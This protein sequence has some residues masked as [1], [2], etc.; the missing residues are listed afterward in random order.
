MS[1]AEKLPSLFVFHG[2]EVFMR[3]Q[4]AQSLVGRLNLE[5]WRIEHVGREKAD[6]P[7][8]LSDLLEGAFFL[9]G[10]FVVVL[11]APNKDYLPVVKQ[12]VADP[13]ES[14]VIVRH[15]K[16]LRDNSAW[17]KLAKGLEQKGNFRGYTKPSFARQKDM[18]RKFCGLMAKKNGKK[19]AGKVADALI[20]KYGA[21]LAQLHGELQKAILL[22]DSQNSDEITIQNVKQVLAPFVE[23]NIFDAVGA[24]EHKNVRQLARILLDIQ[25]S[26]K[27]D[28]TMRVVHAIASSVRKWMLVENTRLRRLTKEEAQR[29][30]GMNSWVYAQNL[31]VGARWQWQGLVDLL[32]VLATAERSVL[33]G[34]LDPW[35]VLFC[36][37]IRAC[38]RNLRG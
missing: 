28:A 23:R 34:G 6:T 12:H 35:S 15:E 27:G 38:Q 21:N 5:G 14:I 26:H 9:G 22:S 37:L 24:L 17:E 11:H 10:K 32:S 25:K 13:G 16:K 7:A 29:E 33:S 36:G 18:A 19:M 4:A 3:D 1:D 30:V 8:K 20:H 2:N 31:K